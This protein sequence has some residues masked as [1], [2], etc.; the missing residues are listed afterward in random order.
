MQES[1]VIQ[2]SI[3]TR[4]LSMNILGFESDE[5]KKQKK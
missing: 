4:T 2:V 3:Y 5:L 1:W